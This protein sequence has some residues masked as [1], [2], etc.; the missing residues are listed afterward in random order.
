MSDGQSPLRSESSSL[1][2]LRAIATT[3]AREVLELGPYLLRI[4][5]ARAVNNV[6]IPGI[7]VGQRRVIVADGQ[8]HFV[9]TVVSQ[10]TLDTRQVEFG[11]F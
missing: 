9:V 2:S 6:R 11:W 5:F 4:K 1:R 10:G 3:A 8:A 7:D